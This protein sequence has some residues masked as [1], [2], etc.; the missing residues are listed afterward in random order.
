M[1]EIHTTDDQR[2]SYEVIKV[3]LASPGDV[4][5]ECR[6]VREI[7]EEENHNHFGHAG[8][9]LEVVA[10]E[11]HASPGIGRPHPQ[12]RINLSI[13]DCALFVVI[14]WTRFGSSTGRAESGTAEEYNHALELLAKPDSPLRDIKI[15]FCDYPIKP[16]EIDPDQFKKVQELKEKIGGKDNILYWPVANREQFRKDFR[17][18]L[19]GWGRK[20]RAHGG[21]MRLSPISEE[22]T[23][24]DEIVPR[25]SLVRGFQSMR[26][27]F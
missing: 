3:F 9:H 2:G 19:A 20:Y 26:K 27:G 5:E 8:Y 4:E 6:I 14:L 24:E 16:S 10:W 17:R 13:N 11:S 25:E 1:Q 21:E 15:Y 22:L 18:H 23:S 7:V 12:G